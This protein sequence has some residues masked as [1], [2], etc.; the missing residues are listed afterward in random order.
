MQQPK[1]P[2]QFSKSG[3]SGTSIIGILEIVE[4]DF[5]ESLS[6]EEAEEADKQESYEIITQKNKVSKAQKEQDVK[7]KTKEY[8]SLDKGIA[9]LGGDLQT[10]GDELDAVVKYLTELK[11]RCIAKPDTYEQRKKR[12]DKEITGL[13]EAP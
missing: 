13:K 3:G 6:K 4:S 9:E 12:R 10:V 11:E 1:K 8:K 7:Y 2:Q 5:A